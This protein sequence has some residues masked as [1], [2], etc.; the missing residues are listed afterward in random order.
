MARAPRK[1]PKDLVAHAFV[2]DVMKQLDVKTT[3]ELARA[4]GVAGTDEE[5]TV[6]RWVRGESAPNFHGTMRLLRAARRLREG[7]A[8]VEAAGAQE[9]SDQPPGS[10][11][12]V[13]EAL[14]VTMADGLREVRRR[15]DRIE[16]RLPVLP[17]Q[18]QPK[19][20]TGPK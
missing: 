1:Q 20:A 11:E 12:E 9:P 10:I 4:L 18:Q 15:L 19:R 3:R 7:E 2:K 5:V 16:R 6:G 17:P 8:P 14:G 13:V